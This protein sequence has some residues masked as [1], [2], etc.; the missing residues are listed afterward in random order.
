[1][2]MNRTEHTNQHGIRFYIEQACDFDDNGRV[3]AGRGWYV[4]IIRGRDD[5]S[6]VW[7]ETKEAAQAAT[8]DYREA[9]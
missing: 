8:A 6:G 5:M 9:A 2:K 1:M 3:V 7:F 4:G